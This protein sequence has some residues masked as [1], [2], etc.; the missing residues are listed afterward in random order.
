MKDIKIH[1]D[2]SGGSK[3][4]ECMKDICLKGNHVV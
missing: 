4:C 3:R 1:A 2:G